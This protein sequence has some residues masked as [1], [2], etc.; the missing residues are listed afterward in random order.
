MVFNEGES[1]DGVYV[2]VEEVGGVGP[3]VVGG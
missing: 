3:E 1:G 2:T